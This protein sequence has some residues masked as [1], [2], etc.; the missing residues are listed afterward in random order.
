MAAVLLDGEKLAAEIKE[1]LRKDIEDLKLNGKAPY[2]VAVQVGENAASRVYI[3][4]QKKACEEVSKALW[5][6]TIGHKEK[7]SPP[8]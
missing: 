2:L 6:G 4:Q 8:I 1:N 5:I 7:D 3:K